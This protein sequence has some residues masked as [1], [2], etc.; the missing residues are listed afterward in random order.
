MTDVDEGVVLTGPDD[1][2]LTDPIDYPEI[3]DDGSP[4]TAAVVTFT[5]TDPEGARTTWDVRGADAALFTI[6]GGVL[7]FKNAP[8]FEDPKDEAVAAG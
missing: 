7:K 8:D 3:D 2:V 4:N 6:D 1:V 5:G